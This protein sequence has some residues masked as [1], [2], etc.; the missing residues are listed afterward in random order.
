M[1]TKK[2]PVCGNANLVLMRG[3]SVKHCI[4]CGIDIPWEL[5]QGQQPV[6]TGARPK[7]IPTHGEQRNQ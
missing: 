2:C 6:P 7:P 4:D 3:H 5:S 1:S